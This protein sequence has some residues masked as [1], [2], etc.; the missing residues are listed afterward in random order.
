MLHLVWIAF[1]NVRAARRGIESFIYDALGR[2][3]QAF[4]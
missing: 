2:D 4:E 3:P 1:A